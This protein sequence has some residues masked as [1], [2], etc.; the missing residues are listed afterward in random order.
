MIRE[1]LPLQAKARRAFG[2]P[3]DPLD[4]WWV[5][6]RGLQQATEATVA[7]FKATLF[8]DAVVLD[9][10]CG[11]GADLIALSGRGPTVGVDADAR[12]ACLAAANLG[13]AGH[14]ST[15]V[16]CGRVIGGAVID[17]TGRK[18]PLMV[19]RADAWVHID[20]D[21][22]DAQRRH[23]R[24]DDWS[25]NWEVVMDW[26]KSTRGGLVKLAPATV[27]R[28]DWIHD[29]ARIWISIGGRVRE[30]TLV[31]GDLFNQAMAERLGWTAGCRGAVVLRRD[32]APQSYIPGD[33]LPTGLVETSQ[34]IG[35]WMVDPDAS[36]RAAGLTESMASQ[37]GLR[38]LGGPAGF[39]TADEPPPARLR[40]LA[41]VGRVLEV[42]PCREKKWRAYF[43]RQDAYPETIKV[44]GLD[45]DPATL[46]RTLR[47]LGECPQTMWLGR[48][49]QRAYCVM[50]D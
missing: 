41:R 29:T 33:D 44:R 25:P 49:S 38:C 15:R 43:R 37:F 24:A 22:R 48:T 8:D 2:E 21:R 31:A 10:C 3:A 20:P 23:T 18:L 14:W 34:Q 40:A 9:L 11:L 47:G 6:P 17:A 50:T 13:V 1:M 39:L 30:Q 28:D 32:A 36:I 4:L 16:H 45:R 35:Q 26:L 7:K 46:H 5:T 42:M 27:L 12:I 19:N